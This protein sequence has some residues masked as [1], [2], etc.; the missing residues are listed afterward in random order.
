MVPDPSP[1][2]VAM[3][4]R[5]HFPANIRAG[6]PDLLD[7]LTPRPQVAPGIPAPAGIPPTD[8]AFRAEVT[9]LY[10]RMRMA[11]SSGNLSTFAA[12][13]DSLGN[14]VGR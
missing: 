2:P 5:S 14:V 7:A 1:D 3:A 10:S 11:L 12:A 9:R 8:S 6:A 4:W 13:Y